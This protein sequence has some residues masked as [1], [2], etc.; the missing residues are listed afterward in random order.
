MFPHSVH[1]SHVALIK[2]WTYIY[3]PAPCQKE[4][5]ESGLKRTLCYLLSPVIQ[6]TTNNKSN[7][8]TVGGQL[9]LAW[10]PSQLHQKSLLFLPLIVFS[11][12]EIG[13]HAALGPSL[14][15][16]YYPTSMFRSVCKSICFLGSQYQLFCRQPWTE[17]EQSIF[18][19]SV[20]ALHLLRAWITISLASLQHWSL[21]SQRARR[22][23]SLTVSSIGNGVDTVLEFKSEPSHCKKPTLHPAPI[24]LLLSLVSKL[25]ALKNYGAKY[26]HIFMRI[27][28]NVF[29]Y[30]KYLFC[31]ANKAHHCKALQM[32]LSVRLKERNVVSFAPP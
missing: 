17:V 22:K 26:M 32:E 2:W 25:L 8:Q 19:S 24:L 27:N 20:P 16:P 13:A 5:W 6:Q 21:F 11:N 9:W 4:M 14:F 10:Y 31:Q 3:V 18:V 15:P 23:R 30:A 7:K 1:S 28:P 12:L 29:Y